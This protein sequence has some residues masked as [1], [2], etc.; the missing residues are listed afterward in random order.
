MWIDRYVNIKKCYR[1]LLF[2]RVRYLKTTQILALVSFLTGIGCGLAAVLLKNLVS[3]TYNLITSFSWVSKM[4][5]NWLFLLYPM[6]GIALTVVLVKF[7]I[8]D[9]LSHGVSKVMYAISRKGGKIKLHNTWSS[10]LTSSITVAFGGSV[11]LEAPIVYTGSAIASNISRFFRLDKHLT[12]I[13]VGCG[14]AGAIA[15]AFKAPIAGILFA[16]EVLMLDL[17]MVSVLPMLISS[18]T[19]AL[20]A[21]FFLGHDAQFSCSVDTFFSL[22]TIPAYILLGVFSAIISLYYFNIS[23]FIGKA[24]SKFNAVWKIIIGGVLLGIML[25][26]F[27]PLFGEGYQALTHLLD[28]DTSALLSNSLFYGF[29]DNVYLLLIITL[30]II[31]I[32]AVATN[33]TCASGGVGGVFAPSLFIGGFSGFFVATLLNSMGIFTPLEASNFVLV[34]MSSVM[35]GIMY[36]PLTSIFLIADIT[37]GY[38]LLAPLMISTT[39]SY[40]VVRSVNK[41]SIYAKPLAQKG[42]LMTHNKDKS[43]IH[44]MD[45]TK[46]LETNFYKLKENAKLRDV[47]KAVECSNR[48]FFPVVDDK[49]M[50]KGVLVLDDVRGMLFHPEFYDKIEVKNFMRYS[51]Y[52]I[53][54]IND[55][56]EKIIKK[57]KGVDR[58]TIIV[59]DKGKFAGCMS[60]ANVFQAYQQFIHNNSD[61]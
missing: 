20:I 36:A 2:W 41:Y 44:F 30:S 56:M 10:M 32:K 15:G 48:N 60:R 33:V 37:G 58:Y 26:V 9:D 3:Y 16:F 28:N 52:F 14:A 17:S 12:V 43:A 5:A 45:K 42:D 55:G 34:G 18:I 22:D 59:L 31:I 7:V 24:F 21:F 6:V 39:I 19:A 51:E 11:G 46:L 27:P 49:D 29:K 54:D 1:G 40:L 25:Y 53:V 38:D 13:L 4:G 23:S 57:F 50:F 61:E 47:V 8:K 35:A